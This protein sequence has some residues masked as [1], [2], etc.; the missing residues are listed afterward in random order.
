MS[1]A[2]ISRRTFV[3]LAVAGVA[4]PLL[5]GT[6][7]AQGRIETLGPSGSADHPE[8]RVRIWL[9]PGYESGTRPYRTLYMLDGQMFL[10]AM[11]RA[12]I[13]RPISESPGLSRPAASSRS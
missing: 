8:L 5:G 1:E 12:S 11:P 6:A 2:L 7:L 9:P 13:S 10:R 4:V 3:T